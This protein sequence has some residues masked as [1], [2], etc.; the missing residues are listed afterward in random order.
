V[1]KVFLDTNILVYANDHR[2]RRKQATAARLVA[3]CMRQH[4]GVVSTQV[5]HEFASV[6]LS[7]LR[8]DVSFVDR[9]LLQ[10]ESLEIVQL[11]P[12]LIRRAL[13]FHSLHRIHYW[14]AAIVAAAE[15]AQCTLLWSEDF[16]AGSTYGLL[17][18]ENPLAE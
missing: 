3:D 11:T 10:F 12:P 16:P 13:Q 2:D 7:K 15:A 6:A 5:L 9:R 18:V 17:R 14:D 4:T 1:T 8:Q